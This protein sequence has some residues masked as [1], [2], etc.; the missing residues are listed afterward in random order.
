VRKRLIMVSQKSHRSYRSHW[1]HWSHLPAGS[2][3]TDHVL[4]L[5]VWQEFILPPIAKRCPPFPIPAMPVS[6]PSALLTLACK[7]LLS[8]APITEHPKR[9]GIAI[10]QCYP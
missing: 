7:R 2:P 10:P 4:S 1:S 3:R 6:S 5:P 8:P 9:P